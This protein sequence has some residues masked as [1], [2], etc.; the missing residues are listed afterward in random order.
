MLQASALTSREVAAPSQ[1][2]KM[3][4]MFLP[5]R[6]PLTAPSRQIRKSP[7]RTKLSEETR[8]RVEWV[9]LLV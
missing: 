9:D 7:A 4:K 2:D 8:S 5:E 1:R 6:P 3:R